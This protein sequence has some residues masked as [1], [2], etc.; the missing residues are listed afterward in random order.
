MIISHRGSYGK[1]PEHSIGSYADAYYGGTDY[2]ELDL[3]LTKDGQLVA[4]HDLHLS[5]TTNIDEYADRFASKKRKDGEFYVYDFTLPE[6]K[7]LKRKQRYNNRNQE[8]NG[9]FEIL[10]L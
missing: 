3:Q 10:T 1:F 7:L 6:L 2:I 9:K 4:Q 8:M 5:A